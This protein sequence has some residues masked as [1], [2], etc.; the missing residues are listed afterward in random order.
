MVKRQDIAK[1]AE[2][3]L[4]NKR[5]CLNGQGNEGGKK[6]GKGS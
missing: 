5:E 3:Y 6:E 2:R 1:S 4:I